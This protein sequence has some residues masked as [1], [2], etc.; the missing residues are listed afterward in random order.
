MDKE[1]I[2]KITSITGVSEDTAKQVTEVVLGFLG[3][4]LPAS[5]APQVE[6]LLKGESVTDSLKDS[7]GDAV[8]GKLGGLGKMFGGD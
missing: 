6:A 5:I 8:G 4:K 3:D 2:E 7:L 1:L